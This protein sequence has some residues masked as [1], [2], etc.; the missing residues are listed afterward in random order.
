MCSRR[1]AAFA[2]TLI[3]GNLEVDWWKLG[4]LAWGEAEMKIRE[5]NMAAGEAA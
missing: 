4:G 5:E 2:A 1:K 3:G